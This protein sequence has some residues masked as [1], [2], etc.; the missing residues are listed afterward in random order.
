M[1]EAHDRTFWRDPAL[2]DPRELELPGGRLRIFET[3]SGSPIV[4]V[5]GLLVNANL[6]R[7]VVPRL[8]P[9]F[10]CVALDMPLGSHELAMPEGAP[11]GAPAAAAMVADALEALDLDQVTLVGNDSGGAISQI[12]VTTR[13]ERVGRLVLTSCD[14]RDNFPP[15]LFSYFKPAAAVPALMWALL[16]PMRLTL[17]RRT[18]IA[19]GWLTKPPID[20]AAEDSYLY[21]AITD[22][23]IRRDAR[24]FIRGSN[25]SQTIAAADRLAEFDRPALIAWSA[26]DRAFPQSDGRQLAADLPN[27]RF[28]LVE[29]A[30]TFSMQDNP[31][32]LSEL[33]AGFVREPVA[34]AGKGDLT[35]K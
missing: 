2:G 23:A 11:A 10:R 13:A 32:R 16:Q 5:H 17:L 22:A 33:I 34:V 15:K 29:G 30:R 31:E 25:P 18:P 35:G 24:A 28:E 14:Y 9:D 21:P 20:R 3:G 7:K 8:A 26:D 4:F 1:S 27:A 12:V 19:F 6:W